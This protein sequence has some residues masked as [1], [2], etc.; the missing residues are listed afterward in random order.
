[1][2]HWLPKYQPDSQ[3]FLPNKILNTIFSRRRKQKRARGSWLGE[4]GGDEGDIG[5]EREGR[6]KRGHLFLFS[7]FVDVFVRHVLYV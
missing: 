5:G 6:K 2:P 7:C 3:N 4:R 1:M